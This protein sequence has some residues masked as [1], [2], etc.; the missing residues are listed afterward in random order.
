[1]ANTHIEAA[2]NA[3]LVIFNKAEPGISAIKLT[4]TNNGRS[5]SYKGTR[6]ISREGRFVYK[7]IRTSNFELQ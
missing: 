2:V 5:F 4:I 6:L 7:V 3:S 1:M